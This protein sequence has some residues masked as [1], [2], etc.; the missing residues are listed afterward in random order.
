MREE[1]ISR[2]EDGGVF[3]SI[4]EVRELVEQIEHLKDDDPQVAY[5]VGWAD[6][7]EARETW[8]NTW[9]ECQEKY[10]DRHRPENQLLIKGVP[11]NP[12]LPDGF[13]STPHDERDPQE[14]RDWWGRSYIQQYTWAEMTEA[15]SDYLNRV[16]TFG[17]EPQTHAEFLKDQEAQRVSWFESWPTGVRYDVRCLDGGAWDRPTG[18]S[19]VG[20][21]EEALM[22]ALNTKR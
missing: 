15:Y 7:I 5:Y 17:L 13:S 4:E 9:N 1:V 21:L 2:L 18:I 6:A 19:M 11:F 12:S 22:I 10:G 16:E 8:K 14:V 3:Q 20:T